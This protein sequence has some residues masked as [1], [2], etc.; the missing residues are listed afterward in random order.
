MILDKIPPHLW[1]RLEQLATENNRSLEAEA[2]EL[3]AKLLQE[4]D[5]EVQQEEWLPNFFEEVI[6]GWEGEPLV[7]EP[8]PE[9]QE[10]EPLL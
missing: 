3:L 6:G 7:R 4:K 5:I 10:R 1:A 8:Q 2:T 9:D